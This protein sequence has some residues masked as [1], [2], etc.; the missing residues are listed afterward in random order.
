M[1]GVLSLHLT[2]DQVVLIAKHLIF[3]VSLNDETVTQL[4]NNNN[5][6]NNNLPDQ[7]ESTTASKN[8]WMIAHGGLL[9]IKYLLASR[10]FYLF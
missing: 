6:N 1:L 7:K 5:N 3:L 10:K 9:G 2:V 8:S 4:C